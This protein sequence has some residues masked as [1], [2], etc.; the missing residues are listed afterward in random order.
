[1]VQENGKKRHKNP[2]DKKWGFPNRI[3]NNKQKMNSNIDIYLKKR[4]EKGNWKLKNLPKKQKYDYIT[5]HVEQG[6]SSRFPGNSEIVKVFPNWYGL[7]TPFEYY[8]RILS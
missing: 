4:A 2:L 3:K 8:R 6:I 1:M 7:K 5:G